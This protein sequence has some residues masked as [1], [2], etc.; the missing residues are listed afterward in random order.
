M[1]YGENAPGGATAEEKEAMFDRFL[2]ATLAFGHTGFFH[3]NPAKPD[4][5]VRSYFA[6]Q[7]IHAHYA[8]AIAEEIRYAD[9]RGKLLDAE[10]RRRHGRLSAAR[11]SPP[12]I[13]TE[14][15]WW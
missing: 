6:L 3:P 9:E 4:N 15:A 2:A 10:R 1:F 5:G 12:A 7:Q 14:C 13:A 8:Q 11:R